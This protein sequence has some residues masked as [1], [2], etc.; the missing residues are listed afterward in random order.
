LNNKL[1]EISSKRY[2]NRQISDL[3][4]ARQ[5][6]TEEINNIITTGSNY[7]TPVSEVNEKIKELLDLNFAYI[8]P[9]DVTLFMDFFYEHY[10]RGKTE[11]REHPIPLEVHMEMGDISFLRPEFIKRVEM[12]FLK[13][14]RKLRSKIKL[15][16]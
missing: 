8:D 4:L 14:Q 11:T 13:K 12:K 16:G 3:P 10:L 15:F 2:E 7:V 6:E 1:N 5:R 9:D